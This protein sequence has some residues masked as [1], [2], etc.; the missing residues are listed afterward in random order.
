MYAISVD[1]EAWFKCT[2]LKLF[3]VCILVNFIFRSLE[4]EY[5]NSSGKSLEYFRTFEKSDFTFFETTNSF[6]PTNFLTIRVIISKKREQHPN[7]IARSGFKCACF[8]PFLSNYPIRLI[9]HQRP[10]FIKSSLEFSQ[11]ELLMQSSCFTCKFFQFLCCISLIELGSVK[12]A[13]I[14]FPIQ[15]ISY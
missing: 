15:P 9:R 3:F 13:N 12:G 14:L 7:S 6:A 10:R 5:R 2:P 1:L 8:C 11:P 4:N